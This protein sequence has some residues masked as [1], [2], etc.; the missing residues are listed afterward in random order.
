MTI[1][2]L[3]DRPKSSKISNKSNKPAG[4]TPIFKALSTDQFEK[5][6]IPDM[7]ETLSHNWDLYFVDYHHE[8]KKPSVTVYF[9]PENIINL[10][11][12]LKPKLNT[13]R[14]PSTKTC[15]CFFLTHG[16]EILQS[17]ESIQML[18]NVRYKLFNN[19]QQTGCEKERFMIQVINMASS[20]VKEPG[21]KINIPIT[22]WVAVTLAKMSKEL[23]LKASDLAVMCFYAYLTTQYDHCPERFV[24]KW[25]ELLDDFMAVAEMKAEGVERMMKV[26]YGY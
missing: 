2:R 20:R 25:V 9:V 18:I 11:D 10:I 4:I 21:K 16:L 7:I 5:V 12:F 13:D 8:P 26:I 1:I 14:L 23:G 17:S 15:L 19:H 3:S 6:N 24:D 22:E